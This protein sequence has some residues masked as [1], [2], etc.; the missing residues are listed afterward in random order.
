MPDRPPRFDPAFVRESW[1]FAADAY[2][3]GQASGNDYYRY[4]FFGPAQVELCGE[5]AGARVLDVGCG[6]GYFARE[7]AQ[8][9]ATVTAID[10]S[11]R[12]IEHAR[13]IDA[14]EPLG[15][16]YE[17][18]DAAG[19]AARFPAESFDLATSCI[20]IPDMP[21]VPTVLRGIRAVLRPGGR[22]VAS[23][24]HPCTDTPVRAWETDADGAKLSLKI[25]R[26]F[27]EG[28]IEFTWKRN[29]PYVFKTSY[30]HVPLERWFQWILEAG[31]AVRG[32][33]EPC[34]TR[35][36]IAAHPDLA[37]AARVPYFLFFDLIRP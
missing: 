9:G 28:P 16:D 3:G 8:R 11:P 22:L 10:I 2:A 14:A 33:R 37:D 31:F 7:M 36:A 29:W 18:L 19:V 17:V 13:R 27:D 23:V 15:I 34:P 32:L 25:D 5:V 6:S 21:D 30:W 24:T 12:M 1:N 4:A 20:S 26:Y 35:D